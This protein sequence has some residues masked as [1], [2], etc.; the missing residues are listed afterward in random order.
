MVRKKLDFVLPVSVVGP[1][2]LGQVIRGLEAS[3]RALQQASLRKGGD[4][5]E[6]PRVGRLLTEVVEANHLNLLHA[7]DRS[8]LLSHL[9]E[10]KDKAPTLHMSFNADPSP[11]FMQ[12]LTAW[13]RDEIHPHALVRTGLLPNIGAGCV[14]RTTNKVFDFSL[15]SKFDASQELLIE[16]LKPVAGAT[17]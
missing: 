16:A 6:L 12:K 2:D 4:K 15:K 11:A 3:D 17:Q 7:E 1:V 14:V 9:N 5:T 13:L 10:L 8:Q